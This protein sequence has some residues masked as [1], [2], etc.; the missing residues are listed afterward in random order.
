MEQGYNMGGLAHASFAREEE[1]GAAF[2]PHEADGVFHKAGMLGLVKGK[3]DERGYDLLRQRGEE[4][5]LYGKC[6]T[7]QEV[8]GAIGGKEIPKILGK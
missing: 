6:P 4:V 3:G 1:G 8:S 2:P 5:V 7:A